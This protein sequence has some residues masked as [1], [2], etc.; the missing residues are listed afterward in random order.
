MRLL[1]E[2]S[3]LVVVAGHG[4]MTYPPTR[5]NMTQKYAG[6]CAGAIWVDGQQQEDVGPQTGPC[7]WYSMG[8]QPGCSTCNPD[9]SHMGAVLGKCCDKVMEPTVSDPALRTY[10][11]VFDS[12]DLGF[13]YN[14][15]RSPGFAPVMDA[16]GVAGGLDNGA[17]IAGFEPG[18]PGSELPPTSGPQWPAGSK[19]EVSWYIW[20]NHGGGYSY[21]LCPKSSNLT[22]ECFQR[23]PLQFVGNTSWIQHSDNKSN[24]MAIDA[25][26]TSE[27][28][29]PP[30]SQWTKNPIPACAGV[31]GG[32]DGLLCAKPQ[33]DPPL[34]DIFLAD[35]LYAQS[36]G[37][38]GF[39]PGG[40]NNQYNTKGMFEFWQ[41]RFS[42]N[43]IDEVLIPEDLTAGE[44]VL[45][46]RWDCEQNPQVW[47]NCADVVI[48]SSRGQHV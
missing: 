31:G 26:R 35:A 33:F 46:F 38:Y 37:L 15:W 10:Q 6:H 1:V 20:T 8:C 23:R 39:G 2:M 48:T 19:Q 7:S 42:F 30:G 24:R 12:L 47:T 44:Y 22:E 16:C 25:V 17:S 45:G 43:I 9:C 21:R 41:K 14:P 34:K 11:D 5:T 13:K 4:S 3:L 36:P 28:T 29:N 40:A 27:G 32:G 18:M